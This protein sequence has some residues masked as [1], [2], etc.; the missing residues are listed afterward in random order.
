MKLLFKWKAFTSSGVIADAGHAW[1][2]TTNDAEGIARMCVAG[3]LATK[4]VRY[5]VEPI[6]S[7][8]EPYTQVTEEET[9]N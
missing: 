2:E 1:G 4:V 7:I 9:V 8:S 6:L 5:L 3:P